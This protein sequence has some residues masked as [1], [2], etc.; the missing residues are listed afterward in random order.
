LLNRKVIRDEKAH[1]EMYLVNFHN[2]I[3]IFL[4]GR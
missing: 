2:F 1:V 4:S 3:D